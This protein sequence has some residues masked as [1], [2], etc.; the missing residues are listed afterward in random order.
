LKTVKRI[1][2]LVVIFSV[3]IPLFLKGSVFIAPITGK[4]APDMES[5]DVRKMQQRLKNWNYYD[6]EISGKYGLKTYFAVRDFQE[7][8]K[9]PVSG[10]A[11]EDTLTTMGLTT[12]A[13]ALQNLENMRRG[14]IANVSHELRTPMTSIHGF[15][16]GILDGTVPAEKQKEYLTIVRDEIKRLNRLTTDILDLARIEAGEVSIKPVDFNINELIRRCI[17]KLESFITEKDISIEASFEEEEMYVKADTD[18]IERV[19]IN[20]VHNAIK[21][22]QPGGKITL[23]TSRSKNKILVCVEDNGIGIDSNELDLIWERF[24][25][26]DKSRSKEKTGTGLGLAIVRNIINDHQQKIW[27]ESQLGKGTKFC[28]TLDSGINGENM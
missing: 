7:T 10:I 19:V 8:Y 4:L 17:I 16:E 12:L 23:S 18:S 11:N 26:S 2:I 21:F 3:S 27:V 1:I 6:G 22:V 9:L 14:F 24:Y 25:K 15:I 20:L 28:F 13:G 5:D